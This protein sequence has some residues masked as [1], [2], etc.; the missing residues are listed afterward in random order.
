MPA[1]AAGLDEFIGDDWAFGRRPRKTPGTRSFAEWKHVST[2]CLMQCLSPTPPDV[3][4]I[5]A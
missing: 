4:F 1:N 5:I 3:A 2:F